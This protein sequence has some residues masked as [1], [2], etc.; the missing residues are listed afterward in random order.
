MSAPKPIRAAVELPVE[1][2]L[3]LRLLGLIGPLRGPVI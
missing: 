3:S 1:V 2:R